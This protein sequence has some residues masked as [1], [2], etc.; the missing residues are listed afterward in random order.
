VVVAV[1]STAALFQTL[2]VLAA[3]ELAELGHSKSVQLL[4]SQEPQILAAAAAAVAITLAF[5]A[6][7]Q[8]AVRV[9]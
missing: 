6:L 4:R 7:A 9:L 3:V 5:L 1:D 8:A 2:A